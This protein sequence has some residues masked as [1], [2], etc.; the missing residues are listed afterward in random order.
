[1]KALPVFFASLLL[2]CATAGA[3][4]MPVPTPAPPPALQP[5][6][7]PPPPSI[8]GS[9]WLLMDYATGQVLAGDNIDARVEPAS[10]T[11]VMTSSVDAAELKAGKI[12]A[13]DP[14]TI[15]DKA[16]TTGGAGT[17][18]ITSFLPLGSQMKFSALHPA[19][20]RKSSQQP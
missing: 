4:Q 13:D 12:H 16:C 8:T 11:K 3:A 15:S 6:P 20:N 1:M 19:I 2:S 14:V 17:D 7:T 9:A 18:G 10:I 5:A